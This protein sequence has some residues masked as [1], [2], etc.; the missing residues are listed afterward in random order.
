VKDF[1]DKIVWLLDHPEERQRM[2]E[3]GRQRVERQLAW[4]Y[5]VENLI[6]A[7][8][9]VFAKSRG[10]ARYAARGAAPIAE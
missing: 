9:R 8:E 7:Y 4:K 5:S 2:G 10:R 3:I 6:A 1:A